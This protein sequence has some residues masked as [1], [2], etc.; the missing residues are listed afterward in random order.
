MNSC[1]NLAP[2]GASHHEV[3]TQ[4]L[5][6]AFQSLATPPFTRAETRLLRSLLASATRSITPS[7]SQLSQEAG[8]FVCIS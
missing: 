5:E 6:C 3:S 1:K 4:Q 2:M 7:M 8:E